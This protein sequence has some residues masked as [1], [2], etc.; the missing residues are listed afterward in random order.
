MVTGIFFLIS[1]LK[2]FFLCWKFIF[3]WICTDFYINQGSFWGKKKKR[4]WGTNQQN[5]KKRRTCET[6]C[7][8]FGQKKKEAGKAF[9]LEAIFLWTDNVP[10]GHSAKETPPAW[11][12]SSWVS[13]GLP[14][15]S[16]FTRSQSDWR[17]YLAGDEAEPRQIWPSYYDNFSLYR[18]LF[19]R[20]WETIWLGYNTQVGGD[21]AG[22]HQGCHWCKRGTL[23]SGDARVGIMGDLLFHSSDVTFEVV[24]KNT[25]V[26]AN[27]ITFQKNFL[28]FGRKT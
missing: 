11:A 27:M 8:Q 12:S 3:F 6:H 22:T 14:V 18:R 4:D 9:L 19:R 15:A 10:P 7:F 23:Q 21:Y 2:F 20:K 1:F 13:S 17:I 26:I 16:R 25:Y 24:Y 5:K 28:P